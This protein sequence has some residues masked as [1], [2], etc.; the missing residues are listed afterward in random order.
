MS[1]AG[2]GYKLK[3]KTDKLEECTLKLEG[4]NKDKTEIENKV[5][6][7]KN[8]ESEHTKFQNNNK[9]EIEQLNQQK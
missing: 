8:I 4:Y 2:F 6:K 1:F 7:Y 9:K 5:N 3:L